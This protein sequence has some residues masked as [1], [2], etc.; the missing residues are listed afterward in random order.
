M[1]KQ[2][3]PSRSTRITFNAVL[4]PDHGNPNQVTLEFP[5]LAPISLDGLQEV[6]IY[7]PEDGTK[8]DLSDEEVKDFEDSIQVFID[9]R[10]ARQLKK[11]IAYTQDGDR[12][13]YAVPAEESYTR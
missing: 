12:N 3:K 11:Y 1:S 10:L 13:S 4:I 9:T 6:K 2:A 5:N 8:R 7:N